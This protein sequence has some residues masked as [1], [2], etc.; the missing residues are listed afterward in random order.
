MMGFFF[1]GGW[2]LAGKESTR[3]RIDL[4]SGLVG[5]RGE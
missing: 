5:V 2:V 3:V 1:L 4:C